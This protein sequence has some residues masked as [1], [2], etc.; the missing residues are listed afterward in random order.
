[1]KKFL[2]FIAAALLTMSASAD[3]RAKKLPALKKQMPKV[4]LGAFNSLQSKV[5][6]GHLF[7]ANVNTKMVLKA[8]AKAE[9][10]MS[11]LLPSYS[12]E[13]YYYLDS[14]GFIQENLYDGASF[15]VKDNKA[16]FAPFAYCD[17]VEGT[18]E[19][20][21]CWLQKY[22]KSFGYDYKIDSITFTANVVIAKDAA[23]NK[24]KACVGNFN[25]NDHTVSRTETATFGGYYFPE[26]S[27]LM[28][29][30]II[31][32]FDEAGQSSAPM[33]G[34]CY[35][36][37][38]LQPQTELD[39]YMYKGTFTTKD[40][41]D[42]GED[43]DK[44]YTRNVIVYPS[45][46]G[47]YVRGLDLFRGGYFIKFAYPEDEKSKSGY[48]NTS[49][50]VDDNQH[51]T[52]LQ[53]QA[54]NSYVEF[55]TLGVNPTFTDYATV[56]FFVNENADNTIS[57]EGDGMSLLLA[58]GPAIQQPAEALKDMTI[59]VSTEKYSA[60]IKAPIVKATAIEYFDLQG[61][62]VNADRKG[63]LIKKSTMADGSVKSVKVL[64][65]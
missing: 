4:S 51:F 57:L 18:V 24:Y 47:M 60:D 35:A 53:K 56:G 64:N 28:V 8:P 63:M 40:Y 43:A 34:Y 44:V 26:Y 5:Q 2:L 29:D 17:Y 10:A 25:R 14:L 7:D 6:A 33:A 13:I 19:S 21:E 3:N 50:T 55:V 30:D 16:Y 32:L 65:K 11:E 1:M 15:L 23:G 46:D 49:A 48:D 54:D 52:T 20:G 38:D 58:Y 39:N 27:E 61:R 31:G 62:K 36:N 37:F 12:T 45:Y 41:Y 59:I 9:A 22:Y 42:K